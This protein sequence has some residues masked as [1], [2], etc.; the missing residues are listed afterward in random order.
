MLDYNEV[1]GDIDKVILNYDEPYADSS[2]LP[3]YFISHKTS[4]FVKV[5]LTG[6]GGDE[7]FGGYN[8]YLLQ[9]YGSLYQALV[10]KCISSKVVEPMLN[11]FAQK[12]TDS[13]SFIT[14]IKKMLQAIGNDGNNS[15]LNIIQLGF[16]NESLAK[17]WKGE[18]FIDTNKNL[19]EILRLNLKEFKSSLKTARYIDTK[20]SLEGD[21]LVKV[22][23]A[24][25]LT[26]LECRAPFLDH[27]LMEFSYNIPDNF[28]VRGNNKKRIL[29]DTFAYLLP[30]N[31]FKAPKS[32][33]EIP[34]GIWFRNELKDDLLHTLSAKN[35]SSHSYFNQW[36]VT[37]LIDEHMST[38]IDHT[39]KLWTLY[40]FQKW[41]NANF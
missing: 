30:N 3:T 28:L 39:S 33:F 8:K 22:D 32:G 1:I 11:I 2:C 21:L 12:N 9:T 34:I 18:E 26:S 38:K 15:H 24:S 37:S 10:P 6:D 31:F 41:Y 19:E 27:R 13:K 20:I 23:R 35:L 40:C 29:K 16:N 7:V 5:A 36:Y 25:M 4:S 17:L 14:G